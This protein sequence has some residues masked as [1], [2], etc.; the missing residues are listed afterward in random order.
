[1]NKGIHSR[2]SKASRCFGSLCRMLWYQRR[3][4]TTIKLRMFK[5][6]VLPTLL[7]GS[8]SWTPL[9]KHVKRLQVFVMRYTYIHIYTCTYS[10]T[11]ANTHTHTQREFTHT[12][13]HTLH[14]CEV[15]VKSVSMCV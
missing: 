3:F 12:H 2:I 15:C 6:V 9:S 10:H 1:M 13:T 4:K 14:K 11:I 5:A 7:Y 8:E